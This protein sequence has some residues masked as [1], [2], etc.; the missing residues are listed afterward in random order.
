MHQ[1]SA[2]CVPSSQ[3]ILDYLSTAVLLLD[4]QLRL[5]HLNAA[6]EQLLCISTR[7]LDAPPF[8]QHLRF[9]GQI[10]QRLQQ[11]LDNGQPFIERDIS[12]TLL[13]SQR[14]LIV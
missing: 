12:I 11:A 10:E 14:E 4:R 8:Q 2:T 3:Q 6:A 9:S 5:I 1:N 13:P 7:Q